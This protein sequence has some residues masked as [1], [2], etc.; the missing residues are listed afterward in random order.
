MLPSLK[1]LLL[2]IALVLFAV[3]AWKT[4]SLPSAGL[5]CATLALLIA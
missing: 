3:D 4:K 5:A 2:V 1:I